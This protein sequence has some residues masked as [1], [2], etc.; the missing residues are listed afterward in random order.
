[1]VDMQPYF[2]GHQTLE[3]VGLTAQYAL[4]GAWEEKSL[5]DSLANDSYSW[6]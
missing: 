1:M 3:I 4:P 2:A 6:S 5:Q